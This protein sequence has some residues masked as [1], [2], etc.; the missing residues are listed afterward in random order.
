MFPLTPLAWVYLVLF[1][2]ICS[3][4]EESLVNVSID[5]AQNGEQNGVLLTYTGSNNWNANSY[6]SS[7]CPTACTYHPDP[8]FMY[9]ETW[10]DGA[11]GQGQMQLSI[12]FNGMCSLESRTFW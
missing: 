5:D 2:L 8:N 9:D 7:T 4:S 1:S 6:P 10:H 11:A 12:S 3:P